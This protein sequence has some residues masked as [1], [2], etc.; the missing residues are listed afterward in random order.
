LVSLLVY[1]FMGE[2]SKRSHLE[3]E[4]RELQAGER[5]FVNTAPVSSTG[6]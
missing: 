5:E 2:P 3:R 6:S 1:V 4:T